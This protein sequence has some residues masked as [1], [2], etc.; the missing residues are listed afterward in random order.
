M[1]K[2]NKIMEWITVKKA[3][4]AT[5]FFAIMT[6]IIDFSPIGTLGL[7]KAVPGVELLDFYAWYST[8]E[9]YAVLEKLGELGRDFCLYKIMPIDIFFPLSVMMFEVTWMSVM[10]K[11][12][13]GPKNPLR[14]LPILGVFGMLCDWGEN[15]GI[16][17]MLKNYPQQLE[18]VCAITGTISG[19][20]LLC[21][22]GVFLILAIL[23]I[24]CVIKKV[25]SLGKQ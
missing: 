7:M 24:A 16:T 22:P 17:L 19:I 4:I 1:K 2:R 6:Y 12:L 20:K 25:L 8:Q 15:I 3:L 14:L 10:L 13:S 18:T 5:A 21:I 11:Y 23:L 9:C